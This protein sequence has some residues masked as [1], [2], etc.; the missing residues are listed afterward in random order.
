MFAGL[1]VVQY[2]DPPSGST[3]ADFEGA[4]NFISITCIVL[5][6]QGDRL[7]TQWTIAN[8]RGVS[9]QVIADNLAPE[10]FLFSGD[11]VPVVPTLNFRNRLM[12][13]T[14]SPDLDQATIFRGSGSLPNQANVTI[15]IYRKLSLL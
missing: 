13:L 5:N 12:I 9:S 2:I 1:G 15:R 6:N 11:P 8:F 4:V 7:S 10:L 14:L 3:I